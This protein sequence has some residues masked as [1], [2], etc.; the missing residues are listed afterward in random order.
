MD[1]HNTHLFETLEMIED[2][3]LLKLANKI[4]RDDIKTYS[5]EEA[6]ECD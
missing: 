5:H 1:I 2:I 4:D 6:W 3:Y